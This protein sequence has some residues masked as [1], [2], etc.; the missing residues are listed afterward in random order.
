MT[1]DL[2]HPVH[3]IPSTTSPLEDNNAYSLIVPIVTSQDPLYTHIFHSYEDI[4]EEI[5]TPDFP[6]NTLHHR[7]LFISQL[8]FHPP[9]QASMC[10]IE[11]KDFIPL[12][13]IDWF[14]NPIPAPDDF[15]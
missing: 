13:N 7:A 9:T 1:S 14:N 8:A 10:E 3:D 5:T 12:G 4:L 2:S 11:T 6:W 15:E